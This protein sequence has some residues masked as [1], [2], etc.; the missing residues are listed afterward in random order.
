MLE[1]FSPRSN[2]KNL[3]FLFLIYQST[4]RASLALQWGGEAVHIA[5]HKKAVST[6]Y[7]KRTVSGQIADTNEEQEPSLYTLQHQQKR[8][9]HNHTCAKR[10]TAFLVT[11]L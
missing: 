11:Q 9:K 1:R 2:N 6:A 10:N 5:V 7:V 3:S 4:H 8:K